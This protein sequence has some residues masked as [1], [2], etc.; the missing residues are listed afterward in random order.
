MIALWDWEYCLY[1]MCVPLAWYFTES[2]FYRSL[3]WLLPHSP[4]PACPL[5]AA[6]H[7]SVR[8]E[9]L[10]LE[11]AQGQQLETKLEVLSF[12]CPTE[13]NL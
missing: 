2:N 11:R 6:S 4:F 9:A 3:Q 7:S 13:G 1:G 12:P 5:L 10:L 8:K